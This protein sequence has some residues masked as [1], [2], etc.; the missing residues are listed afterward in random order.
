VR[1]LWV[2]RDYPY[3][4]NA[5]DLIYTSRL[6]ESLAAEGAEVTVLCRRRD[7]AEPGSQAA[8]VDWR[9]VDAPLRP[10][11]GSLVSGLPSIAYRYSHRLLRQQLDEQLAAG[12]DVVLLDSVGAGWALPAVLRYR[13]R[14]T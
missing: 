1:C 7:G 8:G 11:V 2:T 3:P 9:V 10:Q 5:G 12:P 13:R 6:V 4:A 14:R